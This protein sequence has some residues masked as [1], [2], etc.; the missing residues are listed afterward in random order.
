VKILYQEKRLNIAPK[1][2]NRNITEILTRLKRKE[3][4]KESCGILNI[5][6]AA[7]LCVGTKRI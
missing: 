5:L 6:E 7:V 4:L 1:N 2:A 3:V